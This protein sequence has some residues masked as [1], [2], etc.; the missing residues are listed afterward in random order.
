MANITHRGKR[1]RAVRKAEDRILPLWKPL[2]KSARKFWVDETDLA[3]ISIYG[4]LKRRGWKNVYND[5]PGGEGPLR[6][7]LKKGSWRGKVRPKSC[8]WLVIEEQLDLFL[9]N[10]PDN[11]GRWIIPRFPGLQ[12]A[13]YKANFAQNLGDRSFVPKSFR[14]PKQRTQALLYLMSVPSSALFILKASREW[15][16]RAMQIKKNG[17]ALKKLVRTEKMQTTVL[18]RYIADPLLING[19]KFHC[20]FHV[21]VTKLDPDN[22]T[23][24]AFLHNFSYLEFA[25]VPY[26]KCNSDFIGKMHLT[27]NWINYN[28]EK[29]KYRYPPLDENG[30]EFPWNA[31]LLS[32]YFGRD[33]DTFFWGPARVIAKATLE[34]IV[35]HSSLR[36]YLSASSD[37]VVSSNILMFEL[38]GIDVMFDESYKMWLL[39][40]NT[41][42][43]IGQCSTKDDNGD[44]IPSH[45]EYN[46]NISRFV[47]GC[48][49]II[50]LDN[51]KRVKTS[52]FWDISS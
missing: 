30:S 3:W 48:L 45:V 29:I 20:R 12:K 6:S 36:K 52:G 9:P 4:A 47:E 27:N 7:C 23:F 31:D 50:G 19:L 26:E 5:I 13:C 49:N 15:K 51:S 8:M 33:I 40:C 34:A 41:S 16:G 11:K 1:K 38:L 32:D 35:K 18:Q 17:P 10:L 44:T 14:L 21:L 25:T 24:Q 46:K 2:G 39:E 37:K 22:K 42:P 28:K 43:G